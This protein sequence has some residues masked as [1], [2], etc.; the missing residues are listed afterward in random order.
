MIASVY[1]I[2]ISRSS[3]RSVELYIDY[4]YLPCGVVHFFPSVSLLECFSCLTTN[5]LS[6]LVFFFSR[7]K[8]Y[9]ELLILSFSSLPVAGSWITVLD[10]SSRRKVAGPLLALLGP[11]P[12]LFY[13]HFRPPKKELYLHFTSCIYLFV[14]RVVAISPFRLHMDLH[15]SLSLIDL[16]CAIHVRLFVVVVV[17][18]LFVFLLVWEV[19]TYGVLPADAR[20]GDGV[21]ANH[22]SY[23]P[24][25]ISN[26]RFGSLLR[27]DGG[28][29]CV[30]QKRWGHWTLMILD[31][32]QKFSLPCQIHMNIMTEYIDAYASVDMKFINK[33]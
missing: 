10:G 27:L 33:V 6:F 3:V 5:R 13:G 25:G 28:V 17:V 14:L 16:W 29:E 11:S 23:H 1:P 8:S 20:D 19:C 7:E 26:L 2:F 18:Y 12:F 32:Q 24:H 15:G 30:R 9:D 4:Y 31:G 21:T 22:L